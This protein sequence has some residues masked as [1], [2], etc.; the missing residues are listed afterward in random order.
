MDINNK[1][2]LVTGGAH[3]VGKA[4]AL[5][6]AR[7]GAHVIVHYHSAGAAVTQTVAEIEALGVRALPV[8]ADLSTAAGIEALFAATAAAFGGLDV[9][10]NSAAS[11]EAS[12]VLTVTRE[13]WQRVLDLNLT[14]PFFCAQAAARLM[15]GRAGGGAI[16]NIG[17]LAGRQPWAKYPAH[18]VSKAGVEMVTKV[19]AKALA[20]EIR[21]NAVAPGPVM[22]PDDWDDARWARSGD[23]TLLKRPGS[24][25]DV[26]RA[27][28]FLLEAEYITGETLVVDGGRLIA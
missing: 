3:R 10:V 18:S 6:L 1:V 2:A 5:E 27:V 22:K 26:A 11:M 7:A 16:V 13:A 12:D 28:L 21:V 9:L 4:I 20:P 15:A 23:H 14:A 24:G 25:Y 8:Q 17:D 19:L